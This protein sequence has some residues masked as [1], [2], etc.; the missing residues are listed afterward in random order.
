LASDLLTVI[1]STWNQLIIM[2]KVMLKNLK[3]VRNIQKYFIKS[4]HKKPKVSLDGC[5]IVYK[6][7]SHKNVVRTEKYIL[8]FIVIWN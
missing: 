7:K 8:S 5:L 6:I 2:L 4:K 3:N 1:L